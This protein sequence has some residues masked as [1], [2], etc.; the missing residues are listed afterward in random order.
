MVGEI[1]DTE[2]AQIA[3]QSSLTGH[4]VLSTVHTND[5][6]A[7]APRLIDMG[8][9]GYLVATSLLG[10]VAQRLIRRVCEECREPAPLDAQQKAAVT[11][12]AGP[13]W[14]ELTF[15]RG[16]GCQTCHES[17]YRG[18][19]GVYELLEI[20]EAMADALRREDVAGYTRAAAKAEGYR[21]LEHTALLY[22][23]RG[24]T[25]IAEVLRVAS[26]SEANPP[27]A[28]GSAQASSGD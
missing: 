20:D 4:L 9:E 3:V 21:R 12:L 19:I 10:I 7:T 8:A 1:R 24:H 28:A 14:A 2:T 17:G 22:A 11:K 25:S 23:R 26:G 5:A 16:R 6:I 27:A 15:S 13:K 18:R